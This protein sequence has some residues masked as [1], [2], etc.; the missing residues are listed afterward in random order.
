MLLL[1]NQV[2][3]RLRDNNSFI[4]QKHNHFFQAT[5]ARLDEMRAQN[6]GFI[7]FFGEFS[8][9][10]L[11]NR[12]KCPL[13][14]EIRKSND[15]GHAEHGWLDS[16]HSFSF[17]DYYDPQHVNFHALRVINEDRVA[18][19]AGFG[20]HPHR[21]MEIITYVISGALRHRDSMGNTAV[22]HAGDVQR[23][24]AGTGITHSEMNDSPKEPVHFLQIWITPDRKD[25]KPAYAEKSFARAEAGRLHLI[26]SKLGR[27]GSIPINQDADVFLGKLEEGGSARHTLAAGRHAWLQLI[28]GELDANGT[29][30]VA[31]DAVAISEA[32]SLTL[33][34]ITP[35]DFLIFDLN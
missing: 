33:D 22:M 11:V 35:S 26:A 24:S 8:K 2:W 9:M 23:I 21:D 1:Q 13:M 6:K 28:R 29:R 17:A 5:K 27:D 20:M 32:D 19:D 30:L 14:I 4:G 34:A 3:F 31:G 18:P 15:R 10:E 16:R 25:A 7:H 12:N